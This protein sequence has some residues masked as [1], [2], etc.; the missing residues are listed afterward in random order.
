MTRF[1]IVAF[2]FSLFFSIYSFRT[3]DKLAG[4]FFV[5]LTLVVVAFLVS[6]ILG[7]AR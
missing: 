4:M 2:L 1:L 3:K 6:S 7:G 5:V